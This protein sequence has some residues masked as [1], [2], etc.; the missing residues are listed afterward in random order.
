M[1]LGDILSISHGYAFKGENFSDNPVL[2]IVMTPGNFK[3]G[4]GFREAKI[5]TYSGEIPPRYILSAGD[6][7]ITMTDLSKSGDTLG[8]PGIVPKNNKTYLHNQRIGRFHF[9][10]LSYVIPKYIYYR[11]F[12]KDYHDF[13]LN[14]ST[15][16]TVKHT[17]PKKIL[18]FEFEL[19][20]V[21]DQKRIANIL[22]SLDDKIEANNALL[23]S[24]NQI[25]R[26][27]FLRNSLKRN[28]SLYIS[29]I[30]TEIRESVTS[31][32]ISDNENYV[33]LEH[34]PRRNVWLSQWGTG[35]EV[36]SNKSRFRRGDILFGKLRPYFHKVVVAPVDGICSTDIIVIRPKPGYEQLALQVLSSDSL[37]AHA[38]NSSN[39][40]RMPRTKWSDL[41][42]YEFSHRESSL[43]LLSDFASSLIRENQ[44]LS[45]VRSILISELIGR[46]R[47]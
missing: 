5:K 47:D 14:N 44:N 36:T 21:E 20:P 30:A 27:D 41:N 16:S 11:L 33:G 6:V 26:L 15:G 38:T 43:D 39:G 8:Y 13:I 42:S 3:V 9:K 45:Q 25:L 2:P 34:L 40:T 24:L 10:D 32:Q 12:Q 46:S 35:A 19:P 1:K 31:S 18:D 28:K 23:N 22:G 37:I 4:G 7:V 17:S 29:D